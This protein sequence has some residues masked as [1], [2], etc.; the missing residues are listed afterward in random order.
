[1]NTNS[2]ANRH[3][4]MFDAVSSIL[5]SIGEDIQR[6]GL[7]DT[8]KRVSKMY[9]E[10]TAGLRE[11][12]P[13]MTCFECKE[14]DQL[15]S[16]C[17]IDYWSLCEHHLVPFHGQVSIGYI[18]NEKIAGLSKFARVVEWFA[19][20]PQIQEN[21]TV[22]IADFI[23]KELS[24]QGVI[25]LVTGHHLCMAMRGVKKPNHETVTSAIRGNIPKGEFFDILKMGS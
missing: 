4:V 24:P 7:L 9:L 3:D 16:I 14:K 19:R 23:M 22:Q 1:M 20:R 15:V 11:P 18:P 5:G 10:M 21:L 12:A 17:G 8:P 13:T 2:G 6:E 25:V